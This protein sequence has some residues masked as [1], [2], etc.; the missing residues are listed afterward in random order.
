MVNFFDAT[1]AK[2]AANRVAVAAALVAP[3]CEQLV[4]GSIC[5]LLRPAFSSH[6]RA[7]CRTVKVR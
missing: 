1:S 5:I 2:G 3:E 7:S 4:S 6:W